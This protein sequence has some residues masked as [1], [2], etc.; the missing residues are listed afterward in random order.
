M[1]LASGMRFLHLPPFYVFVIYIFALWISGKLEKNGWVFSGV[2]GRFYWLKYCF[3]AGSSSPGIYFG[4]KQLKETTITRHE[5][6][7]LEAQMGIIVIL[8]WSNQQGI[9]VLFIVCFLVY[10]SLIS[11]LFSFSV[12]LFFLHG[13][14]LFPFYWL[15]WPLSL[16]QLQLLI[17]SSRILWRKKKKT[18]LNL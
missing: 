12:S 13:T 6:T 3:W 15:V 16:S 18:A 4:W 1:V 14:A 10:S 17:K 8:L 7:C 2:L 5:W 11:C 9:S